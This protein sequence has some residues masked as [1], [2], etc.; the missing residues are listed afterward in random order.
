MEF[1]QVIKIIHGWSL[2]VHYSFY[3]P[4]EKAGRIFTKTM[5]VVDLV[6][7]FQEGFLLTTCDIYIF[8]QYI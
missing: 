8:Y 2:F 7:S 5:M 3:A 6:V 1:F 4:T